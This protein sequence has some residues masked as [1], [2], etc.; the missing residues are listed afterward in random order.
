MGEPLL[1]ADGVNATLAVSKLPIAVPMVGAEGTDGVLSHAPVTA[2]LLP[3]AFV[4]SKLTESGL[5]LAK[6]V[7]VNGD[8]VP[9][10]VPTMLDPL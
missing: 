2:R 3:I 8:E 7:T 6:P 1:S 10:V 4:A 5:L 9:V